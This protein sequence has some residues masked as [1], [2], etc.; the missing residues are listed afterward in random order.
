MQ[1]RTGHNGRFMTPRNQKPSKGKRK[2]A[3]RTPGK[4]AAKSLELRIVGG[5]YRG[6]KLVYS[7]D[8]GVRPM[9]D[10]VREA[11]FNLIGPAV[12][13]KHAVDLFAGT[14]ALGLE[15]LSRGASRATF[16][17][18]H[19]PTAKIV[20]RNIA[21]LEAEEVC[22]VVIGNTFIWAKRRPDLGDT[23]WI[24]FSSPPY[25]FYIDRRQEMLTMLEGLIESAP[26]ESLFVVES[27][28]RF[29]LADLPYPDAWNTR[30]YSP[31]MVGIYRKP[32]IV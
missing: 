6:R 3:K 19:M 30:F 29:D 21:T 16:V 10:R 28:Q 8:P 5:T 17:E 25:D 24:V 32:T 18:Q 26:A 20:R 27:D 1:P 31:A 7:G 13:G 9:K 2:R 12:K 4:T 23:P 22:Q 14:G 11:V 15:S